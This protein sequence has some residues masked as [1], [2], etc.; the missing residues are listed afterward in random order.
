MMKIVVIGVAC[1]FLFGC[2]WSEREKERQQE[3]IDLLY[4]LAAGTEHQIAP[5]KEWEE[6]REKIRLSSPPD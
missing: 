3:Q 6:L 4:R 1:S 2:G 5:S